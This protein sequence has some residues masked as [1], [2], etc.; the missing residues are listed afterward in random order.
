M[1]TPTT[2]VYKRICRNCK[3]RIRKG[4]KWRHGLA[5]EFEHLDCKNPIWYPLGHTFGGKP[6]MEIPMGQ[7]DHIYVLVTRVQ[8]GYILKRGTSASDTV[9]EV[10]VDNEVLLHRVRELFL[11]IL[12]AGRVAVTIVE[13]P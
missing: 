8:N 1:T 5:G 13:Q 9:T 4:E 2:Y 12:D 10:Y 11:A 6:K 3:E 7:D